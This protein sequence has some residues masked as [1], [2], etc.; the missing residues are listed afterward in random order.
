M[1]NKLAF[2]FVG[3]MALASQKI[4]ATD[5]QIVEIPVTVSIAN[6]NDTLTQYN[7]RR[8]V[9]TLTFKAGGTFSLFQELAWYLPSHKEKIA[10]ALGIPL[11]EI[12]NEPSENKFMAGTATHFKI[13]NLFISGKSPLNSISH[14]Y[15]PFTTQSATKLGILPVRN[16]KPENTLGISLKISQGVD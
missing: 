4:N 12:Q 13:V 2:F 9:V 15:R 11:E 16:E 7:G 5:L 10:K 3:L 6:S 14:G 8:A 1:F